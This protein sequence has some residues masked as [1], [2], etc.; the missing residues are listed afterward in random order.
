MTKAEFISLIVFAVVMVAIL[1][2]QVKAD[3]DDDD[4]ALPSDGQ[5]GECTG[6]VLVG[7][8]TAVVALIVMGNVP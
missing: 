8:A 1:A 5:C 7:G 2:F 6:A 4:D 3:D